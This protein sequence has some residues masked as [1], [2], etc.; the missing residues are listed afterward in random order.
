MTAEE[1]KP[2]IDMTAV[3]RVARRIGLESLVLTEIQAK[4][5]PLTPPPGVLDPL[6]EQTHRLVEL[7][8]KHLVAECRFEFTVRRTNTVI[9]TATIAYLLSYGVQ[10]AEPVDPEDAEAFA[11][12][13]AAHHA[14]PFL[15]EHLFSLTS[16]M[17]LPGFLLPVLGIFPPKQKSKLS[18]PIASSE[19]SKS[20]RR[21][22]ARVSKE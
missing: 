19:H 13:N 22:R 16:K 12:V 2:P 20:Q 4:R 21:V 8:D 17:G 6:V 15:R 7:N 18:L 5:F 3:S 10:G 1:N 14:W 11:S 9:L